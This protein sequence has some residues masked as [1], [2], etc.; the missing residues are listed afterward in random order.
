[1]SATRLSARAVAQMVRIG[2][3]WAPRRRGRVTV[4]HQVHR[5]NRNVE[6]YLEGD[7]PRVPHT[8]FVLSFGELGSK[9]RLL[10]DTRTEGAA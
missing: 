10:D 7:D 6:A 5:A 4:I 2:Q 3:G 8:R 1:M 9:Y